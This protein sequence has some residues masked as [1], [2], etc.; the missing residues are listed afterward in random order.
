MELPHLINLIAGY[1]ENGETAL[2][3][4]YIHTGYIGED[5]SILGTKKMFGDIYA[6]QIVFHGSPE[7]NGT[8][9]RR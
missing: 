4:P 3:K 2:H 8:W 7:N 9:K 1:F 6:P 5:S